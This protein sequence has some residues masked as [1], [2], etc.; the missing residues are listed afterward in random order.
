MINLGNKNGI[1][2]G[3]KVRYGGLHGWVRRHKLKPDLCECCKVSKPYDLAN[4]SGKYCRDVNDFE[5][6]CRKC[7]INGDGRLNNLKQFKDKNGLIKELPCPYIDIHG[8][9][10]SKMQQKSIRK[11]INKETTTKINR[12]NGEISGIFSQ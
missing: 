6:L 11:V 5:W 7:H 2:K 12:F 9:P 8:Y 4:I 1:W 10:R 3:D